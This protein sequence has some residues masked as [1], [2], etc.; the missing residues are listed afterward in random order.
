LSRGLEAF[1]LVLATLATI[2]PNVLSLSIHNTQHHY[3]ITTPRNCRT[4]AKNVTCSFHQQKVM[5]HQRSNVIKVGKSKRNLLSPASPHPTNTHMHF[6]K[7]P[8]PNSLKTHPSHETPSSTTCIHRHL[9][10]PKHKTNLHISLIPPY[11]GITITSN[12]NL[13]AT[14][15]GELHVIAWMLDLLL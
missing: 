2:D 9:S 1:I 15:R 4:D 8:P 7:Y 5:H 10:I 3:N 13:N 12:I 6:R 11:S 14:F